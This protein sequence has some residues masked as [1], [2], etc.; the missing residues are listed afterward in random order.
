MN[1]KKTIVML[2]LMLAA[3]APARAQS[4]TVDRIG[5]IDFVAAWQP[6]IR[7]RFWNNIHL[8][9]GPSISTYSWL[10]LHLGVGF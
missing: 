9:L 7:I 4:N 5:Q 3:A 6:G 2:A 10:G 8:F 1:L